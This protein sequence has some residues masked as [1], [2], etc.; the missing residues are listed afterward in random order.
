MSTPDFDIA[1]YGGGPTGLF[2]A[3]TLSTHL[4]KRI[5]LMERRDDLGGC[6]NTTWIQQQY[7]SEHAPR[8]IP[9]EHKSVFFRFLQHHLHMD[10]TRDMASVYGS[11]WNTSYAILRF[12]L[13]HLHWKDILQV[14]WAYLTK[15]YRP[16]ETM[17]EWM[18]RKCIS[19]QGQ[20][21]LHTFCI[22]I[23]TSS[24]HLLAS[25]VFDSPTMLPYFL[26]FREPTQWI[27]AARQRLPPN[28]QVLLSHELVSLQHYQDHVQQ[29]IVKDRHTNLM[30]T[31]RAKHHILCIP[32]MALRDVMVRCSLSL[33]QSI[34]MD[35]HHWALHSCYSSI[36]FQLHFTEPQ[37]R[38]VNMWCSSP[39]D[40]LVIIVENVTQVLRVPSLDPR[41]KEVWSCSIVDTTPVDDIM[42]IQQIIEKATNQLPWKTKPYQVTLFPG[43][44]HRFGKWISQDTAFFVGKQGT[45]PYKTKVH[46][47]YTVGP[48]NRQEGVTTIV[49][50]I[51]C[52]HEFVR[53]VFEI[54]FTSST[55][56]R[57]T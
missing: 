45:I 17:H 46:N 33:Q 1:I 38:C 43:L 39:K 32:P 22:G 23:A 24:R 4:K 49:K 8:V 13:R 44:Q 3:Y 50:A 52:A 35:I 54:D 14:G 42:A 15:N 19:L 31:I 55:L 18:I 27:T 34:H 10:V 11:T 6:W 28:C 9:Y 25:Q 5:L 7:F 41:V 56:R 48:H 21:T 36:G 51:E 47:L 20:Q 29:A 30:K 53:E 37:D 16:N 57:T 2:I 40:G 12:F 26:A